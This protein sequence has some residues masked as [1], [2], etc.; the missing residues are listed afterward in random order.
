[1]Y[2]C[3]LIYAVIDIEATGSKF[4]ADRI[5]ELAIVKH[6]G[7][8]VLS[9]WSSLV[10]PEVPIPPFVVQLTGITEEL[11]AEAPLFHEIAHEIWREIAGCVIVG[12]DVNFDYNF[13]KHELKAAGYD[14]D[15]PKLCTLKKS[16]KF[17]PEQPSYSLGR[18]AE[19][20]G[21]AIENRHRAL[22]DALATA[23]IFEIL[24]PHLEGWVA[25]VKEH[26]EVPLEDIARIKK[27]K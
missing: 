7:R 12:H 11:V 25:H 19:G 5:M 26:N 22:G 8:Q 16:R 15:A 6:D 17:I 13:L 27:A 20:L 18:L 4:P 14:L 9:T 3:A 23:A 24:F 1:V 2:F 10:R 21:I